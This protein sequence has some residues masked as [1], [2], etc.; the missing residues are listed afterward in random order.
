MASYTTKMA[1]ETRAVSEPS[2]TAGIVNPTED[3][4]ATLAYQLWLDSGCPLGSDKEHWFRAETMLRNAVVAECQD[5]PIARIHAGSEMLSEFT[6]DQC[7][8]HW[9]VWER[10]WVGT[11]WVGNVHYSGVGV[12]NRAA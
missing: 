3:E 8:G 5:R 6:W 4:I 11:R 12:S 2:K 1:P 7:E 9:E 10:E